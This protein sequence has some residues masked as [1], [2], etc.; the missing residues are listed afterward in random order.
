[1]CP[2]SR[3]NFS[4]DTN[5]DHFAAWRLDEHGNPMGAPRRFFYGLDGPATH[6]DAQIRHALTRLLHWARR[7]GVSIAIEDL[8]FGAEKTREKHG[9][10]K[11]FRKLISGMP[12][13]KLRARLVSMAAELGITIVV[14]DP[15]TPPAGAPSTGRSP[16]ATRT[17]RPPA[18]TPP[19]SRS[20]DALSD[21]ASGDGRHR[22]HTTRVIVWG[23][24]PPRPDTA[25]AGVRKPAPG[26]PDHGHD[27]CRRTRRERG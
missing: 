5:A 11:R 26:F 22:P 2:R 10:R 6:R 7:K 3:G 1:M 8:D 15:P 16:S 21:T 9:R 17:A 18:T 20:G 23:I 13:A 25:P 12:V 4:V 24:G 14:V 19:A 27:P